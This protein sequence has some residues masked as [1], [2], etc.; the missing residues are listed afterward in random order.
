[1]I[2]EQNSQGA[3]CSS[4]SE[5][6][7]PTIGN[8]ANKLA[9]YYCVGGHQASFEAIQPAGF[10]SGPLSFN[11]LEDSWPVLKAGFEMGWVAI[12][13]ITYI[14]PVLTKV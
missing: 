5:P 11:S 4:V 8:S 10:K 1:M 12:Q 7:V 9:S 3:N 13:A 2:S 6:T 14:P